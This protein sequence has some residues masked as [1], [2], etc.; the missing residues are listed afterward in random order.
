MNYRSHLI[1]LKVQLVAVGFCICLCG[2]GGRSTHQPPTKMIVE[3][4]V[5]PTT[6]VI[7]VG[8]TLQLQA[9]AKFSDGTTSDVTSSVSWKSSDASLATVNSTGLVAAIALG[10]PAVTATSGTLAGTAN[11]AVI[12]GAT[13]N[14]PRFAFVPNM[15]DGTLS[16]FTVDA[17][18]GQLQHNGYQLVGHI[19]SSV[20]VEPR[21]KFVYVANSDSNN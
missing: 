19:P 21:G 17:S 8:S 10:R 2:C 12:L 20:V 11:I 4:D 9:Q 1:A 13:A 18:S 15:A 7:Q 3:I 14:V 5:A 6:A 16:S